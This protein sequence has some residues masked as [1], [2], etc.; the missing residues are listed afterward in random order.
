M[1]SLVSPVKNLDFESP[2]NV[3][4]TIP[5]LMD[6]TLELIEVMRKKSV[7][8]IKDLMSISDKLAM[9]NKSRYHE[10]EPK[11]S[12][13]NSRPS[14]LA[15]N[16]DVYQG[17]EA[18]GFD[19]RRMEFAQKHLRILSGLYGLLRP[20]DLIQPYRLEM[21]TKL[22]FDDYQTL[23][24]YWGTTI[25]DLLTKDLQDHRDTTIV[26]LASNEYFKSIRRSEIKA[27]I[28]DV[29]FKDLKNDQYKI[30]SFYAKKARGMMSKYIIENE[31][32]EPEKL[33]GFN[34]GGYYFD[35]VNSTAT[36]LCFKRDKKP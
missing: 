19:Q 26:N 22:S 25:L 8:E 9:L 2:I 32:D 4:S 24:D 13:T 36:K 11:H 14:I 35:P 5:R 29:E 3:N 31:I 27:T 7:D 28:I 23:Y 30:I 33:T 12:T 34:Y 16:G 17:L 21:G 18:K 10:F 6:C 20:L 1:I 15:F